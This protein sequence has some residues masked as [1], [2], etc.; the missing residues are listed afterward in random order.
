METI[1]KELFDNL[2][3]NRLYKLIKKIRDRY[4]Y[5]IV[6]D[7]NNSSYILSNNPRIGIN[8]IFK[9]NFTLFICYKLRN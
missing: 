1:T 7:D 6:K 2:Q 3:K 8:I 9:K 4:E 5:F